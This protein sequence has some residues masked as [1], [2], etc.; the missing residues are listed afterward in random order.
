MK[1]VM[2]D[3]FLKLMFNTLKNYMN[4]PVL[5]ERIKLEK[6]KKLI[7]NLHYKTECFIS[8]RNLKQC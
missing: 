5:S 1:K 7:S 8:I 2:K 3:I 4:L 6:V